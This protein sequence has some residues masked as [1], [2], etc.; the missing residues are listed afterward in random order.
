MSWICP[1]GT[2]ILLGACRY[3][4]QLSRER[5]AVTA[6]PQ[7]V[8]AY[9]RRVDFFERA[10]DVAFTPDQFDPAYDWSRN[11]E[12]SNVLELVPISAL[13]DVYQVGNRA[14]KILGYW[15]RNV[16]AD[17]DRIVSL[18]AEACS[19]V[20]DHSCDVGVVAI[21][22]YEHGRNV[23]VQLAISDL[24]IGIRRSLVATHSDLSD[25]SAGYIQRALAGLSA[26]RT[27]RGGQGLGAIQQ[28]ATASGGNLSIRSETGSVFVQASGATQKDG[29][30]FFPG[31]QVAVTFRSRLY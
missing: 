10:S 19:N 11:A 30:T 2:I 8:H 17:I 16:T 23:N 18:L 25:T 26:R 4:A 9:L 24:G 12:S 5:V 14:R 15:L 21:Q 3:L 27:G 28:F 1:Y 29:L 13:P 31:T 7:D 6:L 22:K 20:V